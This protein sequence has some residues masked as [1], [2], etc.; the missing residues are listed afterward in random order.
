MDLH[1]QIAIK[2]R[3]WAYSYKGQSDKDGSDPLQIYLR[4]NTIYM[5]D[6]WNICKK[7]GYMLILFYFIMIGCLIHS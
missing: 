3:G 2:T 1:M 6:K 5:L 7:G 4:P